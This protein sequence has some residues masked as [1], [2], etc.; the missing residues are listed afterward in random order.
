MWSCGRPGSL[1]GAMGLDSQ[2]HKS[3]IAAYRTKQRYADG[4]SIKRG[5]RHAD[6]RQARYA[7]DAG[8]RHRAQTDRVYRSGIGV[9]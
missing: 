4:R 2:A 1:H 8:D 5:E 6:L 7:C 9:T 3:Q